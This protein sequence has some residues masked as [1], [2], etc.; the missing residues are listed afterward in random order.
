MRPVPRTGQS[1]V[2]PRGT[3]LL[4]L[5]GKRL[6][7]GLDRERVIALVVGVLPEPAAALLRGPCKFPK[8]QHLIILSST[9]RS[10]LMSFEKYVPT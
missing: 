8:S 1:T 4:G 2:C 9:L 3:L 6:A 7:R 10:E 5:L